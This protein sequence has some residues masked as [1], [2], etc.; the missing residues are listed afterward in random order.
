MSEGDK[1]IRDIRG[2][3]VDSEKMELRLEA[4]KEYNGE[5]RRIRAF[6]R[7]LSEDEVDWVVEGFYR[8]GYRM[9]AD[10]RILVAP[11]NGND[12]IKK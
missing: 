2:P 1:S 5:I 11:G 9:N 10:G 4:L 8:L 12:K 6:F 3:I 7:S